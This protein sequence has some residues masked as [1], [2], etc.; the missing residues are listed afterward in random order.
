MRWARRKGGRTNHGGV[1][2]S[3][4]RLDAG[5]SCPSL[6]QEPTRSRKK[7]REEVSLRARGRKGPGP[8]FEGSAKS[9]MEGR[10]Q[11]TRK[12][13]RETWLRRGS[14]ERRRTGVSE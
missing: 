13:G 14:Y 11:L 4:G 2:S 12:W 9:E 3:S 6:P 8:R 1:T 10:R 5:T 7:R